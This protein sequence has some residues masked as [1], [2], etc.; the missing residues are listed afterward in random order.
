MTEPKLQLVDRSSKAFT[1]VK[2]A[3]K[4]GSIPGVLYSKGKETQTFYVDEG[5][6]AR[7]LSSYGISRKIA[8]TLNNTT[9]YAI[10]KDV[11]KESLKDQFVHIDLQTLDENEKI[12]VTSGIHINNR[13]SIEKNGKILQ[14]Q[15]NEVDILMFP[16]FMPE[17][18]EVDAMLLLEKDNITL[19]D[20][21]IAND[22]NIEFIDELDT[23]IA[24]LV[25]A[26][27]EVVESDEADVPSEPKLVEET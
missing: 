13:E 4:D 7:L 1:S 19:A 14:V 12:K 15:V 20:L 22:K 3:R 24:T 11:Q 23:V 18:V 9:S 21:N 8:V 27:T 16:R 17:T 6:L 26:Q 10:F 25:Y 5:E 2:A